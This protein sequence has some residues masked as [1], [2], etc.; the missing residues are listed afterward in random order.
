[1]SVCK[2]T[3]LYVVTVIVVHRSYRGSAEKHGVDSLRTLYA[4]V[5]VCIHRT[6]HAGFILTA[7]ATY[8]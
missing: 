7:P 2:S 1:M 5:H 6:K 8:L 4:F 3:V